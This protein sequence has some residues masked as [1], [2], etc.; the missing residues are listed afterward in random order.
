MKKSKVLYNN[1]KLKK[2][3]IYHCGSLGN[4]AKRMDTTYQTIYNKLNNNVEWSRSEI[5]KA[6][7][8]LCID[9]KNIGDYFFEL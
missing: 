8:I 6:C 5:T 3:I 9:K 4:F 7:E 1:D 2:A